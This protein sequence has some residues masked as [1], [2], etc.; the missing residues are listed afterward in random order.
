VDL[1]DN[2]PNHQGDRNRLIEIHHEDPVLRTF[3]LFVQTGR[4]VSKY[5]D[6][7]LF[8]KLSISQIKFIVLMAFYF[9]PYKLSGATTATQIARWTDT[10]PHN[11]TTLITRMKEDGFLSAD[12]DERDRRFVRI[13]ITDQGREFVR[14][15]MPVAQEIVNQVMSSISQD[16]ARHLEKLLKVIRQN[17]YNGFERLFESP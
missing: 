11:I 7:H 13:T 6:S 10:E 16:D 5:I 1:K 17:A 3:I 9:N 4:V 12:R 2:R 8:R 14:R 15:N